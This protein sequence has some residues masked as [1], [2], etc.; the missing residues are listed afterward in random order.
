[1]QKEKEEYTIDDIWNRIVPLCACHSTEVVMVEKQTPD[2]VFYACPKYYEENRSPN[3]RPCLNHL[4]VQDYQGMIEKI[5]S[6]L[7]F[8]TVKFQNADLTGMRWT[9]NGILYEV[10]YHRK[11]TVTKGIQSATV[12]M[13]EGNKEIIKVRILNQKKYKEV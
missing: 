5:T 2:S 8:Q 10:V 12:E 11:K 1:M 6:E 4:S 7:A 13:P 9:K 3:E